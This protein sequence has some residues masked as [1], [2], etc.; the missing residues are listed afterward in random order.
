[1]KPYHTILLDIDGTLLDFDRAEQNS[2]RE[3]LEHYGI[4]P[5]KKLLE[6]YH[7]LNQRYWQAFETGKITK[8]QIMG[9][10]FT[11]YFRGIG[12]DIDGDEAEAL[13]RDHLNHSAIL[14]EDALEICSYL[15]RKYDL[16]VV[17]N[18]VSDTQ[19]MRLRQSG[20]EPYFQAVFVSEAAGSQKPLREFFDYCFSSIRNSDPSGILIVGDSLTSDIKGGNDAGIDTCWFNPSV[21]PLTAG[22][23]VDYEIQKL[24]E[25][26][27]FL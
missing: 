15:S 3:I 22:V 26:E 25:L 27:H 19:Y 18:G 17:T 23:H 21:Q 6:D 20:L 11:E 5:E 14:M 1:M 4:R 2:I 16:Y 7:T 12:K 9:Y 13:H 10:R 24:K 8:D